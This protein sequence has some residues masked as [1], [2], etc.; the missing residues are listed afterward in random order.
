MYKDTKIP[1]PIGRRQEEETII[2]IN[3][4][5]LTNTQNSNNP[6]TNIIKDKSEDDT[7][8]MDPIH[9]NEEEN[10]RIDQPLDNHQTSEGKFHL[11]TLKM[12]C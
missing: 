4:T 11:V 10:S 2:Q 12:S 3:I 8:S 1:R 7:S 6:M 5:P 9:L